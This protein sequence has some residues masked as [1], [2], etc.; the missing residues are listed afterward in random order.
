M[1]TRYSSDDPISADDG[2]AWLNRIRSYARDDAGLV[3]S[4]GQ[5]LRSAGLMID[6]LVFHIGTLHP[7]V[8][9]RV[10]A[11]APNEPVKVYE[12]D[13]PVTVSAGFPG[14]PFRD[15]AHMSDPRLVPSAVSEFTRSLAHGLSGKR[16]MS[17]PIL[18]PI[19]SRGGRTVVVSFWLVEPMTFKPRD[20]VIM[21]HIVALLRQDRR[22]R[23]EFG[24]GLTGA[25]D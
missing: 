24:L 25:H 8:F 13:H 20:Y 7:E 22:W 6:G 5:Q 11:W 21:A 4:L 14:S 10:I 1:K 17:G 16:E 23:D 12:R 3:A 2:K 18:A 15:A 9:A 19:H